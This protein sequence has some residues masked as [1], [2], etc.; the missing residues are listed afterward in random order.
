MG[1][2]LFRFS[3][4]SSRISFNRRLTSGV[5]F[6]FRSRDLR[7]KGE[8]SSRIR[9]MR[10]TSI[11]PAS[12]RSADWRT[13]SGTCPAFNCLRIPLLIGSLVR[14][15]SQIG[16]VIFGSDFYH[17]NLAGFPQSREGL[18]INRESNAS[19]I[20]H[21]QFEWLLQREL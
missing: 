13:P 20:S 7:T 5:E 8:R 17:A 4:N 11:R 3:K 16:L 9:L 1:M 10:I 2:K 15:G 12:P 18:P 21:G 6:G 19:S 14:S